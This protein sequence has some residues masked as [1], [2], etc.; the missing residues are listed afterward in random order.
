MN[1][2]ATGR[3]AVRS[4]D[5]LATLRTMVPAVQ[6]TRRPL[7]SPR[8]YHMRGPREHTFHRWRGARVASLADVAL[9]SV[10]RGRRPATIGNRSGPRCVRLRGV[11]GRLSCA[12]SI[13]RR[14]AHAGSKRTLVA[15]ASFT[16]IIFLRQ[17]SCLF[18][19][20]ITSRTRTREGGGPVFI[21][22]VRDAEH[23]PVR[24]AKPRGADPVSHL[25]ERHH[26]AAGA[27]E[28]GEQA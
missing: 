19:S 16:C 17:V 14:S 15:H 9:R 21:E 4:S 2:P 20:R 8:G 5:Y 27:A 6:R 26:P 24:A 13:Q 1:A 10:T 18:T 22:A 28:P 7:I 3:P 12:A 11:A 25:S 23:A